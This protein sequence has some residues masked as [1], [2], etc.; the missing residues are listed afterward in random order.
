MFYRGSALP[1]DLFADFMHTLESVLGVS[2]QATVGQA[3]GLA[4]MERYPDALKA[5]ERA[6]RHQ[7]VARVA[8]PLEDLSLPSARQRLAAGDLT[9][10]TDGLRTTPRT[11]VPRSHGNRTGNSR[12]RSRR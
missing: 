1:L 4:D 2:P 5:I 3:H 7:G 10:A 6:F 12:T 8:E 11:V 9:V